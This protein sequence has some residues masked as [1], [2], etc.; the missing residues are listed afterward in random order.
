MDTQSSHAAQRATAGEHGA[1]GNFVAPL[2]PQS[3]PP[4]QVRLLYANPPEQ[5][6]GFQTPD[7]HDWKPSRGAV[8]A[9]GVFDTKEAAQAEA[10]RWRHKGS[11]GARVTWKARDIRVDNISVTVFVLVLREGAR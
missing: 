3:A 5:F 2:A 1:Q 8:R 9:V 10:D 4:S 7:F 6:N 11:G